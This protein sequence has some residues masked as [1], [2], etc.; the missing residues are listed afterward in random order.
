M[1]PHYSRNIF[2]ITH[3]FD[4][5]AFDVAQAQV[6]AAPCM[7]ELNGYDGID[8]IWVYW[9]PDKPVMWSSATRA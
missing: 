6:A 5:F 4:H 8:T 9:P 2:L 1:W 7:P 3:P